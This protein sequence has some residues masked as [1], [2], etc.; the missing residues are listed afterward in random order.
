MRERLLTE[1]DLRS[2]TSCATSLRK[3]VNLGHALLHHHLNIFQPAKV[4]S[5]ED[6]PIPI[7]THIFE[8]FVA[9]LCHPQQPAVDLVLLKNSKNNRTVSER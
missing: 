2:C 3:I 9:E 7:G 1:R 8:C 5:R 6:G 4:V